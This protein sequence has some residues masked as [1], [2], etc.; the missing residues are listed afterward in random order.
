MVIALWAVAMAQTS[1]CVVLEAEPGPPATTVVAGRFSSPEGGH[2]ELAWVGHGLVRVEGRAEIDCGP[3]LSLVSGRAWLVVSRPGV[4]RLRG[5]EVHIEANSSV[6]L[7]VAPAGEA[8]TAVERGAARVAPD[9][10]VGP[11][12]VFVRPSV[13]VSGARV[14]TGVRVGGSG[15]FRLLRASY[16]GRSW[17]RRQVELEVLQ[18]LRASRPERSRASP[19]ASM[20]QADPEVFGADGGSVGRLFEAGVRPRPFAPDDS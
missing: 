13:S 7:A 2:A 10:E 20:L 1:A 15:Q 17:M 3:E 4:A 16:A 14:A 8:Q 18:R 5:L 9:T 6:V 19:D 11:G 12:E